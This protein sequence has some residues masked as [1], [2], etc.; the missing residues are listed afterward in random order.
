MN[1][2]FELFKRENPSID[3]IAP[4]GKNLLIKW[5]IY[6]H[7]NDIPERDAI[8]DLG[9]VPSNTP[10]TT[11]ETPESPA[12][13]PVI[14]PTEGTDG[15]G[16]DGEGPDGEG[17][18]G[19]GPDGEGNG[20]GEG[21]N[22]NACNFDEKG[23][24][25][26]YAT[27]NT[28]ETSLD[29]KYKVETYSDGVSVKDEVVPFLEKMILQII[30]PKIFDCEGGRL[31]S[32]GLRHRDRRLALAGASAGPADSISEVGESYQFQIWTY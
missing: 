28:E 17:P 25:N 18:D 19:E 10:P 21:E 26:A 9:S 29:Y 1:K 12:T 30:V 5:P 2:E 15:E 22:R 16:P 27:A 13:S 6:R 7:F 23:N 31:L 3:G 32:S 4:D 8:N 24:F 14:S 11:T 20:G